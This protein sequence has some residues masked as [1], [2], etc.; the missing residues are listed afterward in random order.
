MTLNVL[1]IAGLYQAI[2]STEPA[3]VA[4]GLCWAVLPLLA[5][6]NGGLV[7]ARLRRGRSSPQDLALPCPPVMLDEPMT[8][9]PR[10]QVHHRATDT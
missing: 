2:S 5:A 10:I 6:V 3:K 4:N 8:A 9:L 1:S 7:L